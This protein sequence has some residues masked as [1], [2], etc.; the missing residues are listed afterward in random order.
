M[1]TKILLLEDEQ[2]IREML[3]YS[4]EKKGYIVIEAESA[5][6]AREILLTNRPD[7]I[8]VD[9]MMPGESGVEFIKQLKKD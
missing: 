1:S 2:P 7:I 5:K 8:I 3:R 6:Q 4:L 9:W